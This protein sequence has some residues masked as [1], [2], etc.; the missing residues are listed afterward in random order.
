MCIYC[1]AKNFFL[2]KLNIEKQ[3]KQF[4]KT[5]ILYIYIRYK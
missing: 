3:K 5:E 4:F 1:G 2:T